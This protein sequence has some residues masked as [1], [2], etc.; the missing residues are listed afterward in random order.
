MLNS[1]T[2]LDL[3]AI[4]QH[5]LRE[6]GVVAWALKSTKTITI[7]N[8]YHSRLTPQLAD[9]NLVKKENTQTNILNN[10]AE[11]TNQI[12]NT[13]PTTIQKTT[14]ND[15]SISKN[16]TKS[17]QTDTIKTDIIK[18]SEHI[19][20]STFVTLILPEK[21]TGIQVTVNKFSLSG[22]AYHNWVVLIDNFLINDEQKMI[23]QSL[24][25]KLTANGGFALQVQYPLVVNDYP[26]YENFSQG[27]HSL[28]G[29]LLRLCG[30]AEQ[31]GELKIALL[32]P[33]SDGIDLGNLKSYCQTTPTLKQMA[34][35]G[36]YKKQFWQLLHE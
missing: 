13:I 25:D 9:K 16:E 11:L 29:F 15:L 26:E 34:E 17:N 33:L 7:N 3:I 19:T 2:P 32:T 20:T 30:N 21:F 24:M 8:Q 1:S 35:F 36:E 6:M 4:R 28:L 14:D 23:W 27:T 22:I 5:M 10:P 18:N 12:T 31:K